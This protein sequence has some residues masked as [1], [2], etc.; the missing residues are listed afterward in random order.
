MT[1]KQ[2]AKD[3]IAAA[4]NAC[5]AAEKNWRAAVNVI[6]GSI[7]VNGCGIHHDRFELQYKLLEAQKHIKESLKALEGIDWPS[8]ADYD[9]AD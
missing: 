7:S 9:M 4:A 6:G 8:N 5:E 2:E 1:N 3:K